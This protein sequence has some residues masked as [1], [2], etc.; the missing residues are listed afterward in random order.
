MA[1]TKKLFAALKRRGPHRVLRGDLSFA[2][3][4]GVV[5][6]PESGFN[7]P[8]VAFGHEWVTGVERYT[9]TLE[10]LASWGIVAAAPDTEKGIAPS[11]LNLAFDLGTTLD[12]IAGVRLG[13]GKISVHPAKLG[14]AGHGFGASAAVFAAAGM[15]AKP[16]AVLA[17]FPSVTQPRAEEAVATLGVP[18]LILTDPGDPMTLRSNAVE[19]ARAWKPAT[20]RSMPKVKAGG[21]VEGRGLA[22]LVG[23]PG[24]DR[25]T[26]RTVRALMTGYLLH[27]LAGDKTYRDF[28]D[29]EVAL[30]KAA[31]MDPFADDPVDLENK[32]V[33]LLKP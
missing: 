15:P 17:A 23:L 3:L 24:A 26:Q 12:I 19:L 6:T 1:G 9:G 11:V 18:G 29:P 28:A 30:P 27:T 20:L 4:R 32:V 5:Y 7:M 33:A 22:R 8:G 13:D 14:L 2:G 10:H 21:V 31:T 16:K 25:G